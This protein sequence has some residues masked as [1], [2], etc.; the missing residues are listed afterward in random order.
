MQTAKKTPRYW[1]NT[2]MDV[3]LAVVLPRQY[4]KLSRDKVFSRCMRAPGGGVND[5]TEETKTYI[6]KL[7]IVRRPWPGRST[8]AYGR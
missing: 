2:Y 4:W 7:A 6:Q 1:H 8:I 3:S 5:T